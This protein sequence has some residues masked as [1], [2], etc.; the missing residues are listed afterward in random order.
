MEP[1]GQGRAALFLKEFGPPLSKAKPGGDGQ[2]KLE[3]IGAHGGLTSPDYVIQVSDE[4]LPPGRLDG[5]FSL[6]SK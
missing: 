4:S 5:D 2:V 6:R 1:R 3:K